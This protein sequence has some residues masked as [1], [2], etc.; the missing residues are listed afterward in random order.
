MIAV[1]VVR[2]ATSSVGPQHLRQRRD[3]RRQHLGVELALVQQLHEARDVAHR[4]G[5]ARLPRHGG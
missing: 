1:I 2:Y 5:A 4:V 3:A